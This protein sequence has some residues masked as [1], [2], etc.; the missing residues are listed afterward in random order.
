M[1]QRVTHLDGWECQ[2]YDEV[3]E[4]VHSSIY[5]ECSCPRG[6]QDNLCPHHGGDRTW[7][8]GR[9]RGS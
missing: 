5:C 3:G 1:A 4:P 7:E 2:A 6:L 9:F 8:D